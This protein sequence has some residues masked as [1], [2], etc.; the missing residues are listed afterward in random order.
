MGGRHIRPEDHKLGLLPDH[1]TAHSQHRNTS[2]HKP[3]IRDL[4]S[5]KNNNNHNLVHLQHPRHEYELPTPRP[6]PQRQR[7][8]HYLPRRKSPRTP[9]RSPSRRSHLPQ[10]RNNIVRCLRPSLSV[11]H[12]RR[13][14]STRTPLLESHPTT[15][16]H[17]N[18]LSRAMG[19][20]LLL[21]DRVAD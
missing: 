10:L 20:L 3:A 13:H 2:L 8:G 17:S 12:F 14:L 6:R 15:A 16:D 21:L 18:S 7:L 5:Y 4:S 1:S 19:V 9:N 11:Y